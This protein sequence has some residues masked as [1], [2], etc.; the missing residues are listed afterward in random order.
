M[1]AL[2]SLLCQLSDLARQKAPNTPFSTAEGKKSQYNPQ[3]NNLSYLSCQIC[4]NIFS[5]W[6]PST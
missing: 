5:G 3:V 2:L 4:S 6:A 1:N